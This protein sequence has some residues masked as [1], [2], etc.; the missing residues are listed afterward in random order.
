MLSC[1]LEAGN[2]TGV[3]VKV[4]EECGQTGQKHSRMRLCALLQMEIADTVSESFGEKVC[5]CGGAI[6]P[7]EAG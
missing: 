7:V 6:F 5:M 1:I 3:I 2:W 4:G